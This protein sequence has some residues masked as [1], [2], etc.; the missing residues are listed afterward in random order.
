M[1]KNII[2]YL[3]FV[4]AS[5]LILSLSLGVAMPY[6]DL[7]Y[8]FAFAFPMIV[9]HVYAGNDKKKREE[10]AGVIEIE[11][12]LFSFSKEKMRLLIPILF[13]TVAV[14][15]LLSYLTHLFLT[16]I[17]ILSTNEI[18]GGVIDGILIYALAPS[19]LEEM[20]FRYLPIKLIAPY[21]KKWTVALS[22]ILFAVYHL[23]PSQLLYALAAGVIFIIADICLESVWPSLILHFL[24]NTAS[25]IASRLDEKGTWLFLSVTGALTVASILITVK[26][27][28]TYTELIRTRIRGS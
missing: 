5:R 20:L 25:V 10:I 22:S 17:G 18:T 13:P 21:S 4:L 23:N 12:R 6:G 11:P 7:I 2:Y 19:V 15:L 27:R 26:K 16:Q 14:I 1:K 24:N 3:F 9:G 8:V 28:K